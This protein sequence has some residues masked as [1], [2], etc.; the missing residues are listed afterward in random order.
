MRFLPAC[1]LTLSLTIATAGAAHAAGVTWPLDYRDESTNRFQWDKRTQPLI[2]ATARQPFASE[3]AL[4]L[5]GPPGPVIVQENRYFSASACV[6]HACMRKGLLW[7]DTAQG[8][9]LGAIFDGGYP[10]NTGRLMLDAKAIRGDVPDAARQA[11]VRWLEEVKASPTAVEFTDASGTRR[12][13]PVAAFTPPQRFT[14]PSGGPSF[15]CARARTRIEHL[16]CSDAELA[17][18]D[19]K[20]ADDFKG[21]LVALDD[22][23]SRRQLT[24][25]QQWWLRERD[26]DCERAAEPKACLVLAYQ[27]QSA[28]LLNW[29]PVPGRPQ[30]PAALA[31]AG[32]QFGDMVYRGQRYTVVR[33]KDADE[34]LASFNQALAARQMAALDACALVVDLPVGTAHGNHSYG[35][36]CEQRAAPAKRL[37]LVCNDD[38]I[39]HFGLRVLGRPKA[40]VEELARFVAD[41]CFGG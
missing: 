30:D 4:A 17:A 14:P 40:S 33:Q 16:L 41:E 23:P 37:V 27:M 31:K 6:P 39:G 2:E 18:L 35:G 28:T 10:D 26:A 1:W 36:V 32:F 3:L 12:P 20:L 13:L 19:L 25:L 11:I 22:L 21:G 5:G 24:A 8:V 29:V 34:R 15:D 38:M 9:G 7:L